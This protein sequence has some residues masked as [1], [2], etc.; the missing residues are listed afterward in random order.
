MNTDDAR[1]DEFDKVEWYDVA[2][3]C[4]PG[5]TWEEYE[6]MWEEFCAAKADYDRRKILQ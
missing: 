6:A 2:R 4:K 1:L 3:R 5:L